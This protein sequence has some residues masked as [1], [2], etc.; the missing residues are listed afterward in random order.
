MTEHLPSPSDCEL[1]AG[2]GLCLAHLWVLRF[3]LSFGL[4]EQ[5]GSGD[6]SL[7]RKHKILQIVFFHL[8]LQW[9]T[10]NDI[11][12][13]GKIMTHFKIKALHFLKIIFIPEVKILNM[14][15]R[16]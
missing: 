9:L 16:L 3:Y 13:L 8:H 11:K 2:Q 7:R 4:E 1:L 6:R 5:K 12:T 14:L 15:T 10:H